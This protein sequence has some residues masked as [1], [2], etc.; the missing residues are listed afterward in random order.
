MKD[1]FFVTAVSVL[2]VLALSSA[3][4][5][6][7]ETDLTGASGGAADAGDGTSSGTSGTIDGGAGGTNAFTGAAAYVPTTGRNTLRPG[8]H[9]GAG[10]PSKHACMECHGPGG[11]GPRFFAAGSVFTDAAGTMPAAQVEVRL[12]DDAGK[13]VSTF[14]DK[15]GNFFVSAQAATTAGVAFPLHAGARTS[16][17]TSTMNMALPNGDC[18]NASCHGGA[19]GFIH[20]P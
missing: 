4:G 5:G 7:A 9:P 8:D 19:Q 2:A 14:S 3:C 12:R 20:V 1:A 16:A 15:L 13:A 17:A 6:A 18:N 10:N 11:D